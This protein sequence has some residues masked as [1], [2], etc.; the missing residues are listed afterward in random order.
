M[1]CVESR[2][3]RGGWNPKQTPGLHA[4]EEHRVLGVG[5]PELVK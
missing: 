2:K 1:R 5:L 4:D 3:Y